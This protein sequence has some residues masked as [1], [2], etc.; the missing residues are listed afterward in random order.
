VGRCKR[1]IGAFKVRGR[2]SLGRF[3]VVFL[4]GVAGDSAMASGTQL[5]LMDTRPKFLK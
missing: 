4:H 1:G 2:T 5:Y 3:F